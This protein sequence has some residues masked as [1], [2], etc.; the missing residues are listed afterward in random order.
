MDLR[1]SAPNSL[2]FPLYKIV[3][4]A[5]LCNQYFPSLPS[6]TTFPDSEPLILKPCALVSFSITYKNDPIAIF[7]KA[8]QC[9]GCICNHIFMSCLFMI[10]RRKTKSSLPDLWITM[11]PTNSELSFSSL[12]LEF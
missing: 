4:G 7:L 11:I 9:I 2:D 8:N 5:S 3:T 12:K 6:R 1:L 10:G